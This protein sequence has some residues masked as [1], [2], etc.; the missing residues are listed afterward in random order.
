[1]STAQPKRPVANAIGKEAKDMHCG[2]TY[3]S[4]DAGTRSSG[5]GVPGTPYSIP[6]VSILASRSTGQTRNH[7]GRNMRISAAS[8]R[9]LRIAGNFLAS[10][11]NERRTSFGASGLDCHFEVLVR[12]A[13]PTM[14]ARP[15]IPRGSTPGPG[16]A[17][18]SSA[19]ALCLAAAPTPL[20]PSSEAAF[21]SCAPGDAG[22]SIFDGARIISSPKGSWIITIRLDRDP[23]SDE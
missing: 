7:F 12:S 3:P 11:R 6:P 9:M 2:L 16:H 13:P 10:C 20:R 19:S 15:S 23:C 8:E 5:D 17:P 14:A 22:P 21:P 18:S 1:M 4:G